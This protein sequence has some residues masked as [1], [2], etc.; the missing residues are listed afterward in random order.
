L[1]DL[2]RLLRRRPLASEKDLESFQRFAVE[3]K[4]V[5]VVSQLLNNPEARQLFTLGKG[6]EFENHANTLSD[7]AEEVLQRT[8]QRSRTD[9]ICVYR[10]LEDHR[11]LAFIIEYKPPHKVSVEYLRAGLRPMDLWEEVVQRRTIP[12]DPGEKLNYNADRLTGALI[13]QTFEYMIENGLEY[14]YATNGE[15]FVFLRVCEN[16]PTTVY[17]YL[18][19]PNREADE[20]DSTGFRYPFTA[21]ARVLGLCLMALSLVARNQAWRDRAAEQLHTWDEEFEDIMHEIPSSERHQTPPASVYKPPPYPINP[22]SPYLFRTRAHQEQ[23]EADVNFGEDPR[24]SS[25]ESSGESPQGPNPAATPSRRAPG[26]DK[27][28]EDVG[29]TTAF[30]SIRRTATCTIRLLY[31]KMSSWSAT[32][33]SAR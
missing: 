25:E 3:D 2:G 22:R 16:D 33:G 8:Q 31:A 24:T 5:D 1:E 21:V 17:Y 11:S 29:S 27:T 18:A 10:S 6:I 13:T 7:N 12:N 19:E 15:A 23:C 9:Q 28:E 4:V 32:E 20:Q 30:Y 26:G 14:S